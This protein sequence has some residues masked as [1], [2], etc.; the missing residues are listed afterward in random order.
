MKRW[1]IRGAYVVLLATTL[2]AGF[3]SGAVRG[4]AAGRDSVVL[5]EIFKAESVHELRRA[6]V[7]HLRDCP[8]H[9]ANLK[10]AVTATLVAGK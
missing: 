10:R 7:L 6:C 2:V 9:D 8:A 1:L 4:Y 5:D 3:V